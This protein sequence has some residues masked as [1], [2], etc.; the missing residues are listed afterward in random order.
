MHAPLTRSLYSL[1]L[2]DALPILSASI[3]A[4]RS[5]FTQLNYYGPGAR[6]SL[7]DRTTYRLERTSLE[8]TFGFRPGRRT[9]LGTRSEE[10]TSELQS[11]VNIVCRLLLAKKQ[12]K[13]E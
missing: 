9:Q 2:H 4:I 8:G 12:R 11:H 13:N 6:S 7:D 3:E 10:H 1:S 5:D